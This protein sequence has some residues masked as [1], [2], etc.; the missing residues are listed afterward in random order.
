MA[1]VTIDIELGATTTGIDQAWA[2]L[3]DF[4]AADRLFPGVLTACRHVDERTRTVT[5][6]GDAGGYEVTERLVGVDD[7]RRRLAY[8]VVG[9]LFEHHH[10]T[11]EVRATGT[12]AWTTDVLPD[13]AAPFVE[14]LMR[15]GAAALVGALAM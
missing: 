15:R 11:L 8:T 12:V 2:S 10:A 5:F 9:D 14:D 4:G 13:D 7:D 3:R 1:S 6:A